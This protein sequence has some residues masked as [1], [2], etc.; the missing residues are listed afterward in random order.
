MSFSVDQLKHLY[1]FQSHYLNRRGYQYHYLDEGQGE[2]LVMLHGNPSWSFMYRELVRAFRDTHRT[3]V[4]DHMGCGLSDKPPSGEYHYSLEERVADLEALLDEKGIHSNI[5]L[6]MHDWGGAIGMTYAARHPSR[7]GRLIVLN[8]AAFLLPPGK[9]LHWSLSLCRDSRVVQF[10]IL[11]FNAFA[12]MAGYLG[13]QQPMP[14]EIRRAYRGPYDSWRNRIATLRFIQDIPLTP[15]DLSYGLL[16]QTQKSLSRFRQTPMLIC[17]GERDFIF[18][19]DFLRE[20]I[21]RFPKARVHRFPGAGHYVL[22]ESS[23]T[24]VPLIRDFLAAHS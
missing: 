7:I 9:S 19:G 13:C 24:I 17:W 16:Q 10:F 15:T 21:R 11:R 22:E 12:R 18:D 2:P 3:V 23:A 4:P 14:R 8:T 1:D 5:T 6:I 20:W